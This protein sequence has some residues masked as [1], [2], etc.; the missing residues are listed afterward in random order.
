MNQGPD[1]LRVALLVLTGLAVFL[2]SIGR[3]SA[4]LKAIAGDRME[5]WL[6]RHTHRIGSA[7]ATGIAA[8]MLLQSS[9]VAIILTIVLVNAG[10]MSFRNALGVV[11]GAN[12]GTT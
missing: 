4:A 5:A 2:Y 6:H 11:L 9:S 3:L 7:L 1:A 12:I 10:L 8:T